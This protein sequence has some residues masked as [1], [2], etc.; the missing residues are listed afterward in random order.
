MRFIIGKKT[1]E[2]SLI[3]NKDNEKIVDLKIDDIKE[4]WTNGF[5][6]AMK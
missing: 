2:S 3:I 4:S 5:V 6:E 1:Q